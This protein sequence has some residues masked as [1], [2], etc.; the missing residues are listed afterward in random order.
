MRIVAATKQDLQELV[1]ARQFRD[2]L[3][4]RLNV[5]PIDLPPLAEWRQDIPLLVDHFLGPS[6]DLAL[7]IVPEVLDFLMNYS[8]PGNV[9]EL[10]NLVARLAL[11]CRGRRI[12]VADLPLLEALEKTNGN[13]TRAAKLLKMTSS[14][15]RYK[16]SSL[17]IDK[18]WN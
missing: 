10:K 7:E 6:D 13:K 4:Y 12:G 9:R 3:F 15:F 8:W 2:D 1:A 5:V 16:L 18:D 14:K 11:V 17:M